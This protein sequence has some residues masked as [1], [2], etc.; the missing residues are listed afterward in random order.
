M[1]KGK[2][3]IGT[4]V[5]VALITTA[6]VFAQGSP[7]AQINGNLLLNGVMSGNNNIGGSA[8]SIQGYG[9]GGN[10]GVFAFKYDKANFGDS[11]TA[12][13]IWNSS[14]GVF[15]TFII[16][17][18]LDRD[19]YIVHASLEGPEGAVYYRGTARLEH[20]RVRIALPNYFEALTRT[21]GRT[22]TLTNVGGFDRLAV[23]KAGA[24]KVTGGAFTVV[25][26]NPNST[27]EFDWEVKA[28]RADG[29]LLASEPLKKDLQVGGFGPYTYEILAKK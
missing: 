17:H 12:I 15:K 27:Q 23:A 16:D 14:S 7:V 3:L 13:Q 19:R 20:G 8:A 10:A 1:K 21:D 29:P 28:I 2:L 4:V 11:P 6:L 9:T 25:S 5:A 22:V 26:D 18:P 24:A